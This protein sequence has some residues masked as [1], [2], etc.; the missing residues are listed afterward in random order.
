MWD[1]SGMGRFGDILE[2]TWEVADN[3]EFLSFEYMIKGELQGLN[4]MVG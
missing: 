1:V 4:L 2:K 3:I